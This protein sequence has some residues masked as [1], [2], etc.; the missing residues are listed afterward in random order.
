LPRRHIGRWRREARAIKSWTQ[1]HC[2]SSARRAYTFYAGTEDLDAAVL[3]AGRTRFDRG[4]RLAGTIEAVVG[5]LGRGP[6]VYRYSGV[7]KEE[8]AFIACSFW[9]VSALAHTG[10]LDRAGALMDESV[11]LAN[12]LGL[13]SEQIDPSNGEFL[14]NMPQGLSHLGLIDAAQHWLTRGWS[15]GTDPAPKSPARNRGCIFIRSGRVCLALLP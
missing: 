13:F 10:Q 8:G 11:G 7:D 15:P 6:C 12:D 9:L 2:W 3:L 1:Q 14:G 5:E 4:P